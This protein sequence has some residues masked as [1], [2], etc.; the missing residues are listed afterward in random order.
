MNSSSCVVRACVPTF[1][2]QFSGTADALYH[3]HLLF[4]D[5]VDPTAA[6]PGLV[7]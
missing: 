4:D 2:I 6:S 5:V 1:P 7:K 3:R